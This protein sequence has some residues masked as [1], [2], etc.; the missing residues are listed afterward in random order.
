MPEENREFA[1]TQRRTW[2]DSGSER[3]IWEK[4]E[5]NDGIDE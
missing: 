3:D 2:Y 4:K 1:L 5:G